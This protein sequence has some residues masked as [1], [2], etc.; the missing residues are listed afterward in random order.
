MIYMKNLND[1]LKAEKRHQLMLGVVFVIYILMNV[2]TPQT[3]AELV[4]N[5]YGNIIVI[6]IALSVFTHS[7]PVVGILA[8]VA[9]YELI[10]RSNVGT[11]DHGVRNYLP[12]EKSK[13]M[14]FSKYNDFPVTLEEQVV[15]KMAPLV[16]HDAPPNSNYK[17][18]LNALHDASPINYE[19]V[20]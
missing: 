1:L 19:G 4:D 2:Q 16:K 7:N 3:L 17:P 10:K 5:L 20:I 11:G 14:D 8:L 18:V 15:S 9:A 12:S 6:V 13:V